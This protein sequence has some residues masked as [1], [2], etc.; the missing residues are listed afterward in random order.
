MDGGV[1]ERHTGLTR[2]AFMLWPAVVA[3]QRPAMGVA[4]TGVLMDDTSDLQ[5]GYFVLCDTGT[6]QCSATRAFGLSVHPDNIHLPHLHALV[7]SDVTMSIRP[8]A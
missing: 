8:A 4:I 3:A 2:R 6:R 5:P 7:G 1:G